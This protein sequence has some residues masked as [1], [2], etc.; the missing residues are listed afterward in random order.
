MYSKID[1]FSF[2]YR[3]M[4]KNIIIFNPDLKLS[5]SQVLK[6]IMFKRRRRNSQRQKPQRKLQ[7]EA[8]KLLPQKRKSRLI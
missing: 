4:M 8:R 6:R 5:E 7:L 1:I 2:S 3:Q